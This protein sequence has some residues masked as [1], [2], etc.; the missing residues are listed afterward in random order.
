M[1][2]YGETSH[3]SSSRSSGLI[4]QV[5]IKPFPTHGLAGGIKHCSAAYSWGSE[6]LDVVCALP[7]KWSW[8]LSHP[9]PPGMVAMVSLPPWTKGQ[10]ICWQFSQTD[11][12]VVPH[13]SGLRFPPS[14]HRE[15]EF[16]NPIDEA[17]GRT[18]TSEDEGWQNFL[19]QH[20]PASAFFT[21]STNPPLKYLQVLIE[22]SID[23]EGFQ[24]P[25]HSMVPC[26]F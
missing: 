10:V 15:I 20:F 18:E 6:L 19:L 21:N 26:C 23:R 13:H 3:G 11:P 7:T 4:F 25:P 14:F 22:M 12:L 8:G 9:S 5:Q 1:S 24:E 17:L 16:L 2:F